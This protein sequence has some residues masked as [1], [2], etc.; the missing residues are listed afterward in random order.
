MPG[1]KHLIEC[2]CYLAI[3][4][5][6]KNLVNH[7]FAVYSKL[8]DLN[9]VIPKIFKCNNCDALHKVVDIGRSE[10]IPGK[11]QTSLTL[12]KEELSLMIPNSIKNILEDYNCDISNY[13][14]VIDIIEEKRWGEF[15]VL[16][17][18]VMNENEVVKILTINSKNKIKVSTETINLI[19]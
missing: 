11:D 7:K 5:N 8:D 13:D 4:K 18:E 1:I 12:T 6:N 14:H 2:H 16:K 10:L 17:R 3:F 9:N 19:V 15:I